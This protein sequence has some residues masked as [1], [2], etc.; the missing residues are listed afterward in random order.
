MSYTTTH[1]NPHTSKLFQQGLLMV[2]SVKEWLASNEPY[3]GHQHS[4][5]VLTKSSKH[6]LRKLFGLWVSGW[7]G[8]RFDICEH[9]EHWLLLNVECVCESVESSNNK[10]KDCHRCHCHFTSIFNVLV[11]V[12]DLLYVNFDYYQFI[13]RAYHLLFFSASL[14]AIIKIIKD[15]RSF[16]LS[17]ALTQS[18][19]QQF[20]QPAITIAFCCYCCFLLSPLSTL[21]LSPCIS[22]LTTE[23]CVF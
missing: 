14:S 16:A 6:R 13:I 9:I 17:L 4:P 23:R 18:S 12:T 22:S 8:I 20:W 19:A 10:H 3:I 5:I 7:V 1:I 11:M 15:S 21:S 2:K